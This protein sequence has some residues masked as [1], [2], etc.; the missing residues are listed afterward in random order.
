MFVYPHARLVPVRH[1]RLATFFAPEPEHAD[2]GSD[3]PAPTSSS[4]V[5][6]WNIE[7]Y[8]LAAPGTKILRPGMMGMV[9]R[10][11]RLAIKSEA[12]GCPRM[13]PEV[14]GFLWQNG[15]VPS[16]ALPEL[17]HRLEPELRGKRNFDPVLGRSRAWARMTAWGFGAVVALLLSAFALSRLFPPGSFH[18]PEFVQTTLERWLTEPMRPGVFVVTQGAVP[19]AAVVELPADYRPP[20]EGFDTPGG[21]GG[22]SGYS[23]ARVQAPGEQRLVLVSDYERTLLP[24]V[25]PGG[26][27]V[28][29]ETLALPAGTLAEIRA[30][31]RGLNTA[32]VLG[33]H[34]IPRTPRSWR[35]PFTGSEYLWVAPML[36]LGL[37]AL[38][39]TLGGLVVGV[40]RARRLRQV[41]GLRQRLGLPENPPTAAPDR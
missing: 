10:V 33:N 6:E 35:A 14:L 31:A 15:E 17:L 37:A 26:V 12:D 39:I 18:G 30:G 11:D 21:Y 9:D 1:R 19:A 36:L 25:Y 7:T 29:T 38:P 8:R 40:R 23:L 20:P 22:I 16:A 4:T 34:V 41:R 24:R 3:E 2:N 27:A 32:L 13:L 28:P 5:E